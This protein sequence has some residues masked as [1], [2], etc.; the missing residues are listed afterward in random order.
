MKSILITGDRL[1]LERFRYLGDELSAY[2]AIDRLAAEPGFRSVVVRRLLQTAH[3]LCHGE[4]LGDASSFYKRP[5]LFARRSKRLERRIGRL[6]RRPDYVLHLMGMF[7]PSWRRNE[8]PYGMFLDYTMALCRRNYPAWATADWP[9]WQPLER[10]AY[11]RASHL[12]A[13]SAAVG[14]SLVHDYGVGPEKITVT[15][16]S[17]SLCELYA[18]SKQFGSRRLLFYN[19]EFYRKGGDLVL[20]AFAGVRRS[21]P[22]ATLTVV[23]DRL[24]D[25]Y[26]AEGVQHVG[27]VKAEELKR[28]CLATDLILA[29]ARC[30]PF[31]HFL[32]E[33]MNFGVPCV[34]TAREG[35]GIA[36]FLRH[37]Q[38]AMFVR[39]PTSEGLAELALDLLGDRA[40]L[41]RL[42]AGARRV[43]A[44][45]LNWR[46]IASKVWT[47]IE[48]TAAEPAGPV[49][50]ACG[51]PS[52]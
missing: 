16:L 39:E 21:L 3:N 41:E 4:R 28:L 10:R 2:A 35:N 9:R 13:A 44:V 49:A 6:V 20:E 38:N 43:V 46:V 32:V 37:G 34:V 24:P 19:L 48:Q 31:G 36:E 40:C 25:G 27:W 5:G 11:A 42:S 8:I 52:S 1:F 14:D 51:D 22:D 23:G 50:A 47:A 17:G 18:G 45:M 15:G 33:A 7:C 26:A 30:E 12:F 29:P